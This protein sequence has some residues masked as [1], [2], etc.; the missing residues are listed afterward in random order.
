MGL[1]ALF[2]HTY[3]TDSITDTRTTNTKML[4]PFPH[5]KTHVSD[6]FMAYYNS[7]GVDL[8][9][10]QK[11]SFLMN[12]LKILNHYMRLFEGNEYNNKTAKT[13]MRNDLYTRDEHSVL[14]FEPDNN[15]KKHYNKISTNSYVRYDLSH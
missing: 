15:Y 5:T 8:N 6:D 14:V 11:H 2:I 10:K 13:T 4:P 1:H 7:I 12:T 3:T 9:D